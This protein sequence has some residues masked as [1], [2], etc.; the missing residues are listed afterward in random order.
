METARLPKAFIA[1]VIKSEPVACTN[2]KQ[3]KHIHLL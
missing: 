2:L 1:S 3:K